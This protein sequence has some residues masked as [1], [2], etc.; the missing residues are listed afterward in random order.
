MEQH[1][2]LQVLPCFKILNYQLVGWPLVGFGTL[3]NFVILC[4]YRQA[5]C[6]P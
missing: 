3:M 5:H 1:A 2:E 6:Q 4:A